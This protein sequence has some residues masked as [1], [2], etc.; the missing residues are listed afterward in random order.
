MKRNKKGQF[1]KG[2]IPWNKGEF[3]SKEIREK[4]SKAKKGKPSPRKGIAMKQEQKKKLSK[5]L[6]GRKK[7]DKAYSFP[8]GKEHPLY[9]FIEKELLVSLYYG[10]DYS[11]TK[12]AKI[13]NCSRQTIAK[14]IKEYSIE[15]KHRY[16]NGRHNYMHQRKTKKWRNAI[17]KKDNYTCQLCHDRSGN[18]H[19]IVLNAHHIKSWA[20]YPKYRY[21]IDNGI[22]LCRECNKW[23]HRTNP[24][25]HQ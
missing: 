7:S 18:G 10:N 15:K 11:I 17:F 1:V 23:V 2:I 19:K 6:K 21:N 3:F 24:L 20:D 25:N 16:G 14:K 5:S 12:I 22:I 8:N 9:V 13:F 4:M